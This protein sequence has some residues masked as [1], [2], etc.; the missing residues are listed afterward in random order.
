MRP[1]LAGV[2]RLVDAVALDDVAA[3]CP[4]PRRRCR[5]RRGSTGR[6]PTAPTDEHRDLAVGHRPPGRAAV[7]RLPQAA[8][9]RAEVVLVRP[10]IAAGHR[11]R[12]AA[13]R[14]P[15][16]APAQPPNGPGRRSTAVGRIAT[17]SPRRTP[18]QAS[19]LISW[20][21]ILQ[22]TPSRTRRS[23]EHTE[24]GARSE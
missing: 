1:G 11:N 2:G 12:P 24:H 18:P 8:A 15:E 13:A 6:S 23:T 10:R 20:V 5:R 16:A 9:G 4:T 14:R 17:P 21:N 3:E 19:E 22:L 7:G